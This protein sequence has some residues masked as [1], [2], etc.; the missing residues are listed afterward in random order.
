MS[1]VLAREY[2]AHPAAVRRHL[3]A[4]LQA[5]GIEQVAIYAGALHYQFLDD[6]PY[7]FKVNPQFKWW[8]PLTGAHDS[9]IIYSPGKKPLLLYFQPDD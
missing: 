2:P 5:A 6:A 7:P 4:A 9:F 1:D 3:D 8:L